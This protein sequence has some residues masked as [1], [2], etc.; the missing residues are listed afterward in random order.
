MRSKHYNNGLHEDELSIEE[1]NTVLD[2]MKKAIGS[3]ET[4]QSIKTLIENHI[5]N[6]MKG[7]TLFR[8]SNFLCI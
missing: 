3:G 2:F 8:V 1:K 4:V 6:K 7:D 5:S